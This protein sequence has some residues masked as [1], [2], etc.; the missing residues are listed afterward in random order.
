MKLKD[1]REKLG[2][3]SGSKLTGQEITVYMRKNPGAKKDANVRKG[4]EFALDHGGAMTFALKGIEKI[5]RG[6]SK[7]PEVKKALQYANESTIESMKED[8]SEGKEEYVMKKGTYTRK[9]DGKTADKMKK[10]GWKL[11][12]KEEVTEA[13]SKNLTDKDVDA[14]FKSMR[15]PESFYGDLDTARADMKKD[16]SP[17]NSARP[18]VWTSL[19]YPVRDGDYYFAFIDK[20]QKNNMKYNEKMNDALKAAKVGGDK[21]S[22]DDMWLV[23]S[24]ELRTYPKSLGWN[25]TMTREELYGA[26]QHMLGK[27]SESNITEKS[28]KTK[29]GI[30]VGRRKKAPRYESTTVNEN[31]RTLA[32]KGMG[33]ETRKSIKVGTVVDFYD[34]DGN[35]RE[36]KIIKMGQIGDGYTLKD[37]KSGKV[38]K[39]TY[40][41]RMKAKKLLRAYKEDT[42]ASKSL[43]KK[44]AH[45]GTDK[46]EPMVHESSAAWAKSLEKIKNQRQL[47][48]ISDEDKATL[49][50]IMALLDKEKKRK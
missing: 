10:Q 2:K 9:V 27:I 33:A 42:A 34:N 24:R 48:K 45:I 41:D 28:L 8:L 43:K 31:Y 37:V 46:P 21:K 18:K 15:D 20:N 38:Y 44:G 23:V 4:V 11:V 47:D 3:M 32:R 17:K 29:A 35:K 40:H 12:A 26:I 50:S 16:Y 14:Q 49:K 25:D 22:I 13:Y 6:L 5:K 1:L 7:H 19:S 36:G 39:F 30:M